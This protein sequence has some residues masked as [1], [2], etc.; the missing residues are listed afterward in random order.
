MS[1]TLEPPLFAERRWIIKPLAILYVLLVLA[2]IF[3]LVGYRP[4]SVGEV[5]RIGG[6]FV[7]IMAVTYGLLIALPDSGIGKLVRVDRTALSLIGVIGGATVPLASITE[8]VLFDAS[9]AADV[10]VRRRWRDAPIRTSNLVVIGNSGDA[11]LV[12]H[13]S[14][15]E[16]EGVLVSVR[17]PRELIAALRTAGVP[18]R[19]F[20]D[21]RARER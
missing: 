21:G 3:G 19:A 10:A 12:V 14:Q 9:S 11:V 2:L 4:R 13:R 15:D 20:R 18:A 5:A 1:Q 16:P 7:L 8:V 17:R 6:G